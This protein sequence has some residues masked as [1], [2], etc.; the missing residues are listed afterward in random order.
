MKGLCKRLKVWTWPGTGEGNK[1]SKGRGCRNYGYSSRE[2]TMVTIKSDG[3]NFYGEGKRK[4][5]FGETGTYG[6][7]Y[8]IWLHF[9]FLFKKKKTR[10]NYPK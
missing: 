1:G 2:I 7:I 3:N 10:D 9:P 6:I 5:R 4:P 8:R